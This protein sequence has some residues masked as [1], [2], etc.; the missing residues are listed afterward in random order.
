M[1]ELLTGMPDG[2]VGVE[3]AGEVSANDYGFSHFKGWG[4]VGLVTDIDWMRKLTH[5]F[6]WL[7]PSGMQVF[8]V[9][10]LETAKTW[11]SG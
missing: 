11:V 7:S 4:R 2:V 1:I 10:D 3:A 8:P 6:S 5:A 9:T